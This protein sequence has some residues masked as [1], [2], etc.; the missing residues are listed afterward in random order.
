[1]WRLAFNHGI[2]LD[3]II[4]LGLTVKLIVEITAKLCFY[5]TKTVLL[6]YQNC[7]FMSAKLCFMI[8]MTRTKF[9]GVPSV[10]MLC[11]VL[12]ILSCIHARARVCVCVC[13]CVQLMGP[14]RNSTYNIKI[15][16]Q[17]VQIFIGTH[18][19]Y[20]L[21]IPCSCVVHSIKT[22]RNTPIIKL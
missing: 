8:A 2:R 19:S 5:V 20:R 14:I 13:V 17:H 18:M 15:E 21:Q 12:S 10:K 1:M 4:I 9:S 22:N 6:C 11:N 3:S 16:T 7:A